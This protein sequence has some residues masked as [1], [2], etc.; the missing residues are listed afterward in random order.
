MGDLDVQTF[1]GN[2]SPPTSGDETEFGR[3]LGSGRNSMAESCPQD[4]VVMIVLC[5]YN[6]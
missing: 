5:Y 2:P 4:G 3:K 1:L 6:V